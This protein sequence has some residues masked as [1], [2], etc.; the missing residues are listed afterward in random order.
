M[1]RSQKSEVRG[2]RLEHTALEQDLGLEGLGLNVARFGGR[3]TPR[4]YGNFQ[5]LDGMVG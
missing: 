5:V 1:V 4:P 2:K 3:G